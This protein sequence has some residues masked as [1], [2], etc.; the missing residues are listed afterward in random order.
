MLKFLKFIGWLLSF[1]FLTIWL[2]IEFNSCYVAGKRYKK[3]PTSSLKEER[4]EKVKKLIKHFLFWKRI[5][6]E[7]VG[8]EKIEKKVMLFVANHK[9]NVDPLVIL[10]FV[11][12]QE[13]PYI[14]FIAKKEIQNTKI[15]Y[16][17]DLLDVI[18]VDRE[19]IREIPKILNEM[20]NTLQNKTSI[21]LFA[22]GTRVP[23][24]E[25]A[26]FKPTLLDAAYRTHMSIQPTVIYNSERLL[27]RNKKPSKNRTVYISLLET[28]NSNLF[29]NM[30]R[31]IL[32][33]NIHEK[34]SNEYKKI[35]NNII[36]NK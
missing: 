36:K 15:G 16:I 7:N 19:N 3:D 23:G 31:S 10:K 4:Y 18:Y 30:E 28:I 5:K 21:C 24:D 33:K 22:E 14:T 35:R 25:I 13:L 2:L 20:V 17:G 27:N 29:I 12:D 1:P 26:E 9:S 8:K 32:S 6:I 34:I 11:L